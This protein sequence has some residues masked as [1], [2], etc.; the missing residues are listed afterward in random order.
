M[1]IKAY[2]RKS[3]IN[4]RK[5]VTSGGDS[6]QDPKTCIL[7]IRELRIESLTIR[8]YVCAVSDDPCERGNTTVTINADEARQDAQ[9][10]GYVLLMTGSGFILLCQNFCYPSLHICYSDSIANYYPGV[11]S[12]PWIL[13]QSMPVLIK[14]LIVIQWKCWHLLDTKQPKLGQSSTPLFNLKYHF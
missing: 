6:T 12:I 9:I 2:V 8:F 7:D 1:A 13:C 4:S 3:K 5:K 10:I 14:F 11:C